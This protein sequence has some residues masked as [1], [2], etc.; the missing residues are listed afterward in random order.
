MTYGDNI[1]APSVCVLAGWAAEAA[2]FL[3]R[4]LGPVALIL[5][6]HSCTWSGSSIPWLDKSPTFLYPIGANCCQ[7]TTNYHK[8][9]CHVTPP[10]TSHLTDK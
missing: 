10:T 9:G 3:G 1:V 8:N 5:V 2:F 4:G 6:S 7:V